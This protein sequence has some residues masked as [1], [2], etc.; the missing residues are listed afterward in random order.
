MQQVRMGLSGLVV[1]SAGH[2][3]HKVEIV[4]KG[5]D[6]KKVYSGEDGQWFRLLLPGTYNL[7]ISKHGFKTQKITVVLEGIRTIF[8]TITLESSD[9]NAPEMSPRP[10][11]DDSGSK[12]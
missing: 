7:I 10:M 2:G 8:P 5:R 1:N 6:E 12:K 11:E 9:G 3:L 4:V